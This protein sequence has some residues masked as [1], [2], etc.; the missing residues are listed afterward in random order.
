M[1]RR[2]KIKEN[3]YENQIQKTNFWRKLLQKSHKNQTQKTQFLDEHAAKIVL[4]EKKKHF[5]IFARFSL[6]KKNNTGACNRT[7][8][9]KKHPVDTL[10]YEAPPGGTHSDRS[11]LAQIL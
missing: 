9:A 3:F 8:F 4:F 10:V 5:L 11:L 7:P 6:K 2:E 1:P